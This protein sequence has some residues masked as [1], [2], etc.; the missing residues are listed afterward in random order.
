M[1]AVCLARLQILHHNGLGQKIP[2]QAATKIRV[3]AGELQEIDSEID[4]AAIV[5]GGLWKLQW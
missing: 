4:A 2:E 5:G 1:L 3:V